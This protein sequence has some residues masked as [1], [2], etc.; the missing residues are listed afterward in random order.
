MSEVNVVAEFGPFADAVK[1]KFDEMSKGELFIAGNAR[2][3]W[4]FYLASFPE[5]TNEKYRERAEYDCECCKQFVRGIGHAVTI[6]AD[7]NR[8]SVWDLK[9]LEYPYDIVAAKVA[10]FVADQPIE[11]LYRVAESKYG[12]QK[13]LE[14]LRDTEGRL[15]GQTRQWNHFYG[16]ISASHL[17]DQV[18]TK[19]GEYAA[20]AQVFKRGLEE[21]NPVAIKDVLE[22]IADNNLYRGAEFKPGMVGFQKL[23]NKYLKLKTDSA[24]N[25]FIWQHAG[26]RAASQFRS[27]LMGNLI[28]DLSGTPPSKENDGIGKEPRDWEG[29]IA[30]YEKAAAPENFK[31]SKSLVTASQKEE[32]LKFIRE[33]DWEDSLKRRFATLSDISVNNVLW[34]DSTVQ[35][36]MKDGLADL[37]MAAPTKVAKV[38]ESKAEDISI[39][40]FMAKVLPQVKTMEMF[41]KNH[42]INNFMSLTAP[43]YADAK[44]MFKWN[45][46]FAWS[47]NGNIADSSLRQRVESAGGRVDGVLRFSH[48]W[49]Y[50]KRNASL[51]DLHVF[52]P[53]SGNHEDGCHNRY[54]SGQ[55]VGWNQRNDHQSAG[56]Q[57]VDY[58]PA[59]PVGYVPV[60][61]ITFPTMDKLK[62]GDYT[63][64]IHNWQHRAPTEAGVKAEIAFGGQLFQ[65][66]IARPMKDKEWITL[67]VATLKNGEFTI[68]HKWAVGAA[69]QEVWGIQTEKFVKVSTLMKSPNFWDGNETGNKHWFFILD[70]CVNDESTRGIYNE[71]LNADF[72]KH[73]KVFEILGDLMK[74]EPANEQ[75]SGL[76]FSSTRKDTVIVKVTGNKLYKTYNITF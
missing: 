65:Y 38:D 14:Q 4:A 32:A 21:L 3:V 36:K 68:D 75:L 49:N 18:G 52:M 28:I 20:L 44:E 24:K 40:D 30:S 6:D 37:L 19:R 60:E 7:G 41:V 51:M 43:V 58:T 53:G 47:Y 46:G 16:S 8:T 66:E 54:P 12:V 11:A 71:F 64:K 55:R 72:Q 39:D 67:A 17:T 22:L 61:N 57:D 74:C 62:N 69:S 59:A 34:V 73:R 70:Q 33:Q 56:V 5:G 2:E 45:N 15:T 25:T 35:S 27:C 23:Q 50:D 76:G 29:A 1:R 42:Q 48:T 13:N 63:F 26:D 10:K 31:R 9:G